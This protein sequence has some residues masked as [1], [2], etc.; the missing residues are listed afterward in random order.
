MTRLSRQDIE[1]GKQRGL[2]LIQQFG[3]GLEGVDSEAA[4]DLGVPV[5]NIPTIE[6]NAV[7][8]GL[9]Y[10]CSHARAR[11]LSLP[12]PSLPYY[13]LSLS[14]S[15]FSL[16]QSVLSYCMCRS[17]SL[18]GGVLKSVL[19]HCICSVNYSIFLLHLFSTL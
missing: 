15:L 14:L 13:T 1:A 9:V 17:L 10:P 18:C 6:G 4:R 7:S 2:K 19:S 11:S 3:A 12:P 16:S 8:T 5:L